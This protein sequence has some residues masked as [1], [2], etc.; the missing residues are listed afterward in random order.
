MSEEIESVAH[1]LAT[2]IATNEKL[3]SGLE[4][5]R[6]KYLDLYAEY[7]SP[8]GSRKVYQT[9]KTGLKSLYAIDKSQRLKLCRKK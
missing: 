9:D 8:N 3:A 2:M 7:F 1:K 6:R 5:F 4:D